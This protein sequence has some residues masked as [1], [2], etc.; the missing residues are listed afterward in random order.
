MEPAVKYAAL[1]ATITAPAR[2]NAEKSSDVNVII[3]PVGRQNR[4]NISERLSMLS[5]IFLS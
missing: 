4:N 1:P 5:D 2:Q 3:A